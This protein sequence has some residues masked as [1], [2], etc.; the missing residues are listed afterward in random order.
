MLAQ[1]ESLRKDLESS[2]GAQ[3]WKSE[4]Y[5]WERQNTCILQEIIS[6]LYVDQIILENIHFAN[7]SLPYT[8]GRK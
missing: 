2:I 6:K 1:P 5:F 4:L 8:K 3:D 7:S